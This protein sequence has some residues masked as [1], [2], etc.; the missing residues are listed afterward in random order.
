[1]KVLCVLG[2]RPEAIKMAPVIRRL[3]EEAACHEA[4]VCVTGQHREMLDQAL[5]VFG[6]GPDYDLN[7]MEDDQSLARIT[8]RVLAALEPILAAEKPDWVLVQ[9]DTTTAMAAALGAFYQKIRVGHVEAGL[10]TGQKTQPFPEEMNR[11]IIDGLSDLHLA[12]TA[13]ARENL[14]R[15]GVRERSIVV[16]GNTVIDALQWIAAKSPPPSV[17]AWAPLGKRTILVTAH[18]RESFGEPL[19]NICLAVR[20]VA[21][22]YNGSVSVVYPVHPNPRVQEAVHRLLDGAPNVRLLRPLDYVSLIHLMKR[23]YLILTDSGGIQEEAPSLGTPVLVLREVTER[24]E[25]V[26]AGAVRV[27]GTD[28]RAIVSGVAQLL[29]DQAS[30]AQMAQPV[31]P[32]GDGHAAERVVAALLAH[33][34]S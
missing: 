27:V 14:Q 30:Y 33:Q 32:Y 1:M 28:R 16:T 5:G 7:L 8:V 3:R 9:G 34:E 4:Q 19:E 10:R 2:T 11:R 6:I 25:G 23:A 29:D 20:E 24:P 31:N 22:R 15:E 12:P 26:E 18:R 21:S 17:E 13:T